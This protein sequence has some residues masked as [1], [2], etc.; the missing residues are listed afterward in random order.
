MPN[1]GDAVVASPK[2]IVRVAGRDNPTV[3]A[4]PHAAASSKNKREIARSRAVRADI[5]RLS[6]L[7]PDPC[8]YVPYSP[9]RNG[10]G[11]GVAAFPFFTA[12]FTTL[13]FIVV[14]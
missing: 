2:P 6:G 8:S 3:A 7:T 4:G 13:I 9:T 14:S 12:F 11:G 5:D 10:Q 1:C